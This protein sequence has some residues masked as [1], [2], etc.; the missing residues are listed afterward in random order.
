[1]LSNPQLVPPPGSNKSDRAR[2]LFAVGSLERVRSALTA[3]PLTSQTPAD[4]AELRAA[5][6]ALRFSPR[7]K[8]FPRARSLFNH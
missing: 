1:M 8:L 2:S 5:V 7:P 4:W 3:P 6:S